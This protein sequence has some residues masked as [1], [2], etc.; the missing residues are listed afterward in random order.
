MAITDYEL[1]SDVEAGGRPLTQIL[2][3]GFDPS[4]MGDDFDESDLP[5]LLGHTCFYTV[6]DFAVDRDWL[7]ARMD[8]LGLPAWMVPN[9]MTEKRAF[10]QIHERLVDDRRDSNGVPKNV[11]PVEGHN[12]AIEV[13]TRIPTNDAGNKMNNEIHLVAQEYTPS[14]DDD[15]E[16][17]YDDT[18][19]GV[20]LFD[21]E[22]NSLLARPKVE[23]GSELWPIWAGT[24][25]SEWAAA[26]D[27]SAL[28]VKDVD[29]DT[30]TRFNGEW[31]GYRDGAKV[32][33]NVMQ[34]SHTG[35]DIQKMLY[36]FTHHWTRSVKLRGAGAVYFVPARHADTTEKVKVLVTEMGELFKDDG[37]G[38]QLQRVPV[39]DTE[40]QNYMVEQRARV[41]VEERID[42]ILDSFFDDLA[43]AQSED[44]DDEELIGD[45]TDV[46]VDALEGVE[47]I[48]DEYNT[49]LQAEI[50]ARSTVNDWLAD[51]GVPENRAREAIEAA[52][53]RAFEEDPVA[54]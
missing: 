9:Q 5:K 18:T 13:E 35:R 32:L 14:G 6:G 27:L 45:L 1:D 43:E 41:A 23:T 51:Q 36:N 31:Y 17:K 42:S 48:E 40:E 49:L 7:I 26:D 8:S 29:I 30:V 20:F 28:T 22:T 46:V 2:P 39:M 10:K 21:S 52:A 44:V 38:V 33:F 37:Y 53:D 19:I 11:F 50:S 25:D 16:G 54:A 15:T 4:A 34:N 47:N 3:A 24:H 12:G